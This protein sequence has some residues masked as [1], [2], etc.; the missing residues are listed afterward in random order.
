MKGEVNFCNFLYLSK[1]ASKKG[2]IRHYLQMKEVSL[3]ISNR[4]ISL[5]DSNYLAVR[6]KLRDN[7]IQ[8]ISQFDSNYTIIRFKLHDNSI[9]SARPFDSNCIIPVKGV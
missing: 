7:S 9:Q 3:D 1:I 5:F 2:G 6:F 8:I 4:F